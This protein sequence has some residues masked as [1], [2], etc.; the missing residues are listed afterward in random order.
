MFIL[1]AISQ[2]NPILSGYIKVDTPRPL[3]A[4]CQ[5]FTVMYISGSIA[6][7]QGHVGVAKLYCRVTLSWRYPAIQGL[8]RRS[9]PSCSL[10][11]FGSCVLSPLQG[12]SAPSARRQSWTAEGPLWRFLEVASWL[13]LPLVLIQD[14]HQQPRGISPEHLALCPFQRWNPFSDAGVLLFV[15]RM[16]I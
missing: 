10:L 7:T 12:I 8:H 6:T 5:V 4:L 2:D 16:V 14:I 15:S 9:Q 3:S 11:R 1:H 13:F